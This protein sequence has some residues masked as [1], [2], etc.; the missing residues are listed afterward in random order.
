MHCSS[1]ENLM[2][3]LIT[4]A[5]G[6]KVA[7]VVAANVVS[8]VKL[9]PR[10]LER[11]DKIQGSQQMRMSVEWRKETLFQQ[12]DLSGLEGWSEG[13]QAAASALL[14]EYHDILSLE[15]GELGC[16]DLVK[17]EISITEDKSFNERFQRISLKWWMKF[18]H[19][20]RKCLKWVLFTLI[21]AHGVM[22]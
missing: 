8:P 16:T 17:H 2:A 5:K 4:I 20:W 14:V 18:I 6:V 21:K 15:P 9:T 13:N 10:S 1:G 12:L 11:L 3:I 19:M 22:Q 7:Q